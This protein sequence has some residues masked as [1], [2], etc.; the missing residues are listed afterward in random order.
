MTGKLGAES[1]GHIGKRSFANRTIQLWNQLPEAAS[2]VLSCKAS[3]FRGTVR[4]VINEEK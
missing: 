4:K 1:K 3:D 2:G